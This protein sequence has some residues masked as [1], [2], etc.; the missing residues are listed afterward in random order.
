MKRL[1]VLAAFV[2]LIATAQWGLEPTSRAAARSGR[3]VPRVRMTAVDEARANVPLPR[4]AAMAPRPERPEDETRRQQAAAR[5]SRAARSADTARSSVWAALSRCESGGDP[6]ARS[7]DGRYY[8][9]FQFSPATWQSLGYSGRASDHPYA[10]QLRAAQRLQARSGW[11]QWPRC[12]RRL[13]LR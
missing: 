1:A 4:V 8:G 13:G 2:A 3:D 10:T 7:A 6:K 5:T 12:S 11:G 9:A